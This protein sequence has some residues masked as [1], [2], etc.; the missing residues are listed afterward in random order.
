[1]APTVEIGTPLRRAFAH[2]DYARPRPLLDALEQGFVAVE[3][4]VFLVD[5]ALLVGHGKA[6]L[7]PERTLA[8]LYL[9]PL[10]TIIEERGEIWPDL[11]LTLLIDVKSEATATHLALHDALAQH[12]DMLT[13][14]RHDGVLHG[15]VSVVVSG[16]TDLTAMDSQPVRWTS[17]DGRPGDLVDG[18]TAATTSISEK[19]GR[20]FA[21][22]GEGPMPADQRRGLHRLVEE[23]H[24]HGRTA[25]FW[26]TNPAMWPELLAAGVDHII[27]DDLVAMRQFLLAND[28]ARVT[29]RI[30]VSRG[31]R[32][33]PTVGSTAA[34]D[35]DTRPPARPAPRCRRPAR[36]PDEPAPRT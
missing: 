16:H 28:P 5:G 32:T 6:D 7:S 4:D 26:G 1:M 30:D 23:V 31:G 34:P 15:P 9:E 19:F 27:A 13:Q 12:R 25:R 10:A 22:K 8:A 36:C 21:W 3:A 14:H 18:L 24:R 33:P 17:R 11:P 29:E 20:L 35:R 2:N